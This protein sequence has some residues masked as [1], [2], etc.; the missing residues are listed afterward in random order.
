MD[1]SPGSTAQYALAGTGPARYQ[2]PGNAAPSA[3][4]GQSANQPIY[5]AVGAALVFGNPPSATAAAATTT[6]GSG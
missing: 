4:A 1:Q 6:T 2:L 5:G 3:G